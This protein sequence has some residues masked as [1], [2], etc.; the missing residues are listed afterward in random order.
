V[1]TSSVKS[2]TFLDRVPLLV[3]ELI[4]AVHCFTHVNGLAVKINGAAI[5]LGS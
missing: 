1:I 5:W 2:S 3:F 4:Q